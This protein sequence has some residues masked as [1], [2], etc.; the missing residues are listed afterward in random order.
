ME[1]SPT[2]TPELEI[3]PPGPAKIALAPVLPS[4]MVSAP[5]VP[6]M[7]WASWEN[8]QA[9]PRRRRNSPD[10]HRPAFT[11]APRSV[12]LLS[13]MLTSFSRSMVAVLAGEPSV[14]R[15]KAMP[16]STAVMLLNVLPVTETWETPSVPQASSITRPRCWVPL[17]V[18]VLPM[19]W[20]VL[21]VTVAWSTPLSAMPWP[22]KMLPCDGDA[23]EAGDVEVSAAAGMRIDD[24][25]GGRAAAVAHVPLRTEAG[26][27]GGAG[28]VTSSSTIL[29]PPMLSVVV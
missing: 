7:S 10:L 21:P 15:W 4:T 23:V 24:V 11:P 3:C 20:K 1:L 28:Q 12:K 14:K 16:P 13:W 29:A 9:T 6:M 17:A 5:E 27:I 2:P 19:F 22:S 18:K 8:Q 25:D 26:H